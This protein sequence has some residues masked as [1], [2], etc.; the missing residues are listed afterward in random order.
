M[1]YQGSQRRKKNMEGMNG[2]Q[3]DTRSRGVSGHTLPT[4]VVFYDAAFRNFGILCTAV[5]LSGDCDL[6]IGGSS[7]FLT[8]AH[9]C[10]LCSLLGPAGCPTCPVPVVTDMEVRGHMKGSSQGGRSPALV[11]PITRL[12]T[13]ALLVSWWV[14]TASTSAQGLDS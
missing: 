11:R 10:I 5:V 14:P 4:F 1:A 13:V 7:P 9:S 6:F 8:P 2:G 12:G 3:M